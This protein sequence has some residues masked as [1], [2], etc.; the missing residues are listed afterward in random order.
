MKALCS[1]IQHVA[2]HGQ[3]YAPCPP[4]THS[5]HL[6]NPQFLATCEDL[7]PYTQGKGRLPVWL[8]NDK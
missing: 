6:K 7:E 8:W 2:T 3:Y 4:I 1:L 5:K